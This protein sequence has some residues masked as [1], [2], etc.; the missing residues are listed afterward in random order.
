MYR[1][2]R[3]ILGSFQGDFEFFVKK[4]YILDK[5]LAILRLISWSLPDD[6]GGITCMMI[7]KLHTNTE[8]DNILKKYHAQLQR[9]PKISIL[10]CNPTSRNSFMKNLSAKNISMS[11]LQYSLI[12]EEPI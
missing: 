3:K 5:I 1:I 7:L 11:S 2:Y 8:A 9:E 10:K 12:H 6:E 4:W